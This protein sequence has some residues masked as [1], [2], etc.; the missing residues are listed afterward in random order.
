LQQFYP[1]Y[2]VADDGVRRCVK[3]DGPSLPSYVVSSHWL[4]PTQLE[5]G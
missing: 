3:G 2:L 1:A 4:Q 5:T